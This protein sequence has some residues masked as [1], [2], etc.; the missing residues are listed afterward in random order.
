MKLNFTINE[1]KISLNVE[2]E[3]TLLELLRRQKLLS[4]KCGCN[5]ANCGACAVLLDGK[6][7]LSCLIPCGIVR[8]ANIITM[9]HF[10]K[11]AACQ[12]ILKGF[13]KAGV[14]LCG[15]CNPGKIFAAWEI[16]NAY[17][18]PSREQV[19][20]RVSDLRECCVESDALINGI[21]Y[22]AQIHFEKERLKKNAKQ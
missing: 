19:A 16:I 8:N 12:E 11:Q 21:I 22:A 2:P 3:C 15:Y 9:E 7:V 1:E 10:S 6:A 4:V 18:N 14:N 20:E 5:K 13:E 17:S